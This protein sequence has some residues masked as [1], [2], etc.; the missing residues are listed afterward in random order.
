[1]KKSILGGLIGLS[2][3]L[4]LDSL[5]R[6]LIALYV[7]EQILMFSYTGYPG[8][9][10]VIL[11]TMMAGLSSF[12]GAL[13]VLTYDKNHQVA[14]LI[15]FG[16]LLTGFRYGQIHLLYPTEG[17]IYPIIGFILSLIAIFLA[18]KVVRPSKSEKDAGTFNQQHHPVDS[19]K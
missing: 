3:V 13:F 15:L 2:I 14:G 12:L 1:M 4:S 6:V 11:I 9:L 18:W 7:D 19:G 8:W 10:S 5:V 17:I 16:V